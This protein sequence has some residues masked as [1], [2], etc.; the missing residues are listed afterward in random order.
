M[1]G[2]HFIEDYQKL[3]E[4]LLVDHP[5][6]EAMSRAAGGDGN[7]FDTIGAIECDIMLYAGLTEGMS[8]LDLGCGAG[9]LANSL[10]KR[11]NIHYYGIDIVETLLNYAIDKSPSHYH[12]ILRAPRRMAILA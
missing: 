5:L 6:D 4:K 8:V 7:S 10:S 12:F 3:V 9:R 11:I 1:R 2:S